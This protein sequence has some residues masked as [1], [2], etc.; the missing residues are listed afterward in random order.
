[1]LSNSNRPALQLVTQPTTA[2]GP[3]AIRPEAAVATLNEIIKQLEID[4]RAGQDL[5]AAIM[6]RITAL[7]SERDQLR[8]KLDDYG[9]EVGKKN[10]EAFK[11]GEGSKGGHEVV[12][13]ASRSKD[14][15]VIEDMINDDKGV[16]I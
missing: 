2:G 13:A 12:V 10:Y 15:Q 16:E 3:Q 5:G 7:R 9:R 14:E 6:A 1:M 8:Q 4:P 11:K